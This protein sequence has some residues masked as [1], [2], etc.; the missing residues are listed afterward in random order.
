MIEEQ[1]F[2]GLAAS[3]N[4]VLAV[5]LLI[6]AFA[7]VSVLRDW[8]RISFEE[9]LRA[10]TV[11]ATG[12]E[13]PD[14]LIAEAVDGVI[15]GVC[16]ADL[17]GRVLQVNDGFERITGFFRGEVIDRSIF[18]FIGL[19]GWNDIQSFM[20]EVEEN[21]GWSREV[22]SLNKEKVRYKH[23]LALRVVMLDKPGK[24]VLIATIIKTRESRGVQDGQAEL[25]AFDQLTALANK[26]AMIMMIERRNKSKENPARFAI[27]VYIDIDD[28]KMLND[29]FGRECGD[30][31]LVEFG[32]RLK[33]AVPEATVVSRIENDDFAIYTEVDAGNDP[34][35][36]SRK[37]RN[38]VDRILALHQ[39]PIRLREREYYCRVSIGVSIAD[40]GLMPDASAFIEQAEFAMKVAKREDSGKVAFYDQK[41]Q[42]EILDM[43]ELRYDLFDAV[44]KNELFLVYQPQV[45]QNKRVVGVEALVRWRHHDRGVVQPDKFIGA[46]EQTG[47]IIQLGE[48]VL[49]RA[50]CQLA[51]WQDCPGLEGVTV[52]VN[53]SAK[54]FKQP[55]FIDYVRQCLEFHGANPSRLKIELTESEFVRD[56]EETIEKMMQ[57]NS[58]GVKVSLDDFGTG[59]SSLSYLKKL[60]LSQ[61]K[62]DRSFVSD[63]GD[64]LRS[65]SLVISIIAI[66]KNLGLEV[67]AEGVETEEQFKMLEEWGCSQ[68]QGYWL[69]VPMSDKDV[70]GFARRCSS[71]IQKEC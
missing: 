18:N 33:V 71:T 28:F 41:I 21:G 11:E 47:Y 19:T 55:S 70:A 65:N 2:L 9:S 51:L 24:K 67:V 26:K 53:V 22:W 34:V 48:W 60:P 13:F 45:D 16:I 8:R 46:A 12:Q 44:A 5:F 6:S 42:S 58:L 68:F 59:Y 62:I 64:D 32:S 43:F 52:S 25:V 54:E 15:E 27:V 37:A 7:I 49:D 3:F 36:A 66:G 61:I 30:R 69:H 10:A 29:A 57:L 63:I 38:L 14:M 39:T 50:I 23:W 35:Y 31:V 1:N 40:T 56:I 4:G 17:Q 20:Q